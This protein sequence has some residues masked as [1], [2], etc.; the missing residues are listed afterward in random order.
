MGGVTRG[1]YGRKRPVGWRT[2]EG[3]KPGTPPTIISGRLWDLARIGNSLVGSVRGVDGYA[4]FATG[5][6]IASALVK[7]RVP[8]KCA[9]I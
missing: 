2:R 7:V 3:I 5:I 6:L 4:R 9:G 1:G 8:F